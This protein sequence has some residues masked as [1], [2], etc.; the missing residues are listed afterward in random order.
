M[1]S[2]IQ[3]AKDFAT[4]A[5]QNQTEKDVYKTPYIFHLQRVARLVQLS[6]G[7]EEEIASAWL[8][9]TVEDTNVSIED[10]KNEFGDQIAKIVDGLTD[11]PEWS[12]LPN[13]DRKLA[14]AARVSKESES[15]RRV[16][17][18]DQISGGKLDARNTLYDI[19]TRKQQFEGV[20]IVAQACKGVSEGLDNLFDE[21]SIEIKWF[22]DHS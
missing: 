22:L 12:K 21:I 7:S 4:N 17:L 1:S 10:I 13:M 5:H 9:D 20:T 18:A 2:I 16:K 15:V 11:L 6:R 8:H 14:Q 3:K 19:T